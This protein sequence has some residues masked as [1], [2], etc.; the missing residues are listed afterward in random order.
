MVGCCKSIEMPEGSPIPNARRTRPVCSASYLYLLDIVRAHVYVMLKLNAK[1]RPGNTCRMN[2]VVAA[3][4][5]NEKA[6][7]AP[8][9]KRMARLFHRLRISSR[10]GNGL[11]SVNESLM[12]LRGGVSI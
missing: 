12:S 4:T 9:G 6:G 5:Q 11:T 10:G 8:E 1:R 2:D 7:G 3:I